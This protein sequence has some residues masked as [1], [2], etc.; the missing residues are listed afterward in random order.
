MSPKKTMAEPFLKWPG[1]KRWLV[2]QYAHLFPSHVNRYIEP[3]LGGGAV[4][5]RLKPNSAL[6]ADTNVELVNAY[7]CLRSHVAEITRRLGRLDKRHCA[8]VYYQMRAQ[9]PGD[10]IG[11]AVRFIYLN[12]TCF[13]GL[14]RVNK[15]GVFN[16]PMG[17]KV[18]VQYPDGALRDVARELRR[19]SIVVSD[20]EDT[21]EQSGAGDFVFVD[22]PY[23]V[24]HNTNNFVK[25]NA[26]LFSWA[27]Q[28]RLAKAVR[29]AGAR[30]ASLMVSNADHASVRELYHGFGRH[31]Q[32]TR[33]TVLAAAPAHRGQSN[34][35]V[36]TNCEVPS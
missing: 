5:F 7:K 30:G 3:F 34:E 17:S 35:L 32:V 2:N 21:L 8:A 20:F 27:D 9:K 10:A 16:V 19:A 15:E 12:R 31:W 23:T 36:I 6:L 25:Y 18:A 33:A 28:V 14:Y 1:G 24:K 26:H 4:Y 29:R 22:P 13:N 11:R